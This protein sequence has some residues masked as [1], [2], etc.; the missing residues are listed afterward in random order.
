VLTVVINCGAIL[1]QPLLHLVDQH[2]VFGHVVVVQNAPYMDARFATSC[3]PCPQNAPAVVK[4][5][6]PYWRLAT[7]QPLAESA[8]QMVA[9]NANAILAASDARKNATKDCALTWMVLEPFL[10]DAVEHYDVYWS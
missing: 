1:G 2:H 9:D 6:L 4:F 5:C 8:F 3:L 10:G 7:F